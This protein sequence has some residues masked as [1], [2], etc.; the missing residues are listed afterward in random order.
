MNRFTKILILMAA[1]LLA[2]A[3]LSVKEVLDK[4]YDSYDQAHDCWITTDN[5]QQRY[6]MKID[7]SDKVAAN[8]GQR[9]YLLMAGD[10]VDDKGE[11]S[12]SHAQSGLVGA[13]VIEEHDGQAE[14]IASDAKIPMGGYGAAPS[15]WQF[16]KLGASDYWGWQNTT[17]YSGQGYSNSYYVILAPYGKKIHNLAG[18]AQGFDDAGACTEDEQKCATIS[19]SIESTL[20]IDSSQTDAKV[21]PLHITV[22]G[23]DKGKSIATKTWTI[24]FDSKKWMYIEPKDWTLKNR[25]I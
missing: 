21:F 16:V 3:E 13:F 8:T 10:A 22:T 1:P 23:K 18:F 5:E 19:T 17:G 12:D 20:E 7:R 25:D 4:V 24:P 15:Q 2:H 6:C 11:P 9:L 14:I